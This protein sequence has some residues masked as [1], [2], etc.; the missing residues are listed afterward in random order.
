MMKRIALVTAV[1]SMFVLASVDAEARRGR[2]HGDGPFGKDKD[3]RVLRHAQELQLT[4][5]QIEQIRAIHQDARAQSE[6]LRLDMEELRNEKRELMRAPIVDEAAV[7]RI[8]DEMTPIK[9]ALAKL[10]TQAQIDV[11]GILAPEQREQLQQIREER[12]EMRDK[13]RANAKAWKAD[14]VKKFNK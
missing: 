3:A 10:R 12:R 11:L 4:N 8:V 7:L 13:R 14:K 1:A 2:G 9:G 5:A 6:P